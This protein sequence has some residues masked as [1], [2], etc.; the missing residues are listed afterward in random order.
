[1]NGIQSPLQLLPGNHIQCSCVDHNSYNSDF[2]FCDYCQ[3]QHIISRCVL[4][5]NRTNARREEKI[6]NRYDDII[7]IA[8]YFVISQF[9]EISEHTIP[10][11]LAHLRSSLVISHRY[12][13]RNTSAFP[14][15]PSLPFP[16]IDRRK[17]PSEPIIHH[18]LASLS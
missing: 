7:R 17:Q 11:V 12:V 1:M 3:L 4:L 14:S 5:E 16:R 8:E 10:Y 2:V 18:L 13:T 9:T 6:E 15:L